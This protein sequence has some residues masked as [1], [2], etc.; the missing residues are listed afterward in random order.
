MTLLGN[1]RDRSVGRGRQGLGVVRLNGG[2]WTKPRN[3]HP[4]GSTGTLA[5]LRAPKRGQ[6]DEGRSGRSG[7]QSGAV[8]FE[9]YMGSRSR[10]KRH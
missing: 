9:R 7:M 4:Q 5:T 8:G 3:D 10:A 1:G 2:G 6:T